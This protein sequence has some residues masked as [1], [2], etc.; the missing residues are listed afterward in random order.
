MAANIIVPRTV[1][2]RTP[3]SSVSV[4]KKRAID[5]TCPENGTLSSDQY[6]IE[7]AIT[8]VL[9]LYYLLQNNIS[10][11]TLSNASYAIIDMRSV[12]NL[13][14]TSDSYTGLTF[15]DAEIWM[16]SGLAV[17]Q[18]QAVKQLANY[19]S[20]RKP[21]CTN[22]NQ[23]SP[24]FSTDSRTFAYQCK[25]YFSKSLNKRFTNVMTASGTFKQSGWHSAASKLVLFDLNI[26]SPL[27]EW[28]RGD[29]LVWVMKEVPGKVLKFRRSPTRIHAA[30]GL[31]AL[32]KS[33]YTCKFLSR[34]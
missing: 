6:I 23:S 16:R 34:S 20:Y 32:S 18:L 8:E 30:K 19:W 15:W 11:N 17:A 22:K 29:K 12:G 26:T 27:G 9:N 24:I 31:A 21:I 14:L 7:S 4:A 33:F 10:G 28:L 3:S 5:Y 1:T 13:G 2:I 25:Y